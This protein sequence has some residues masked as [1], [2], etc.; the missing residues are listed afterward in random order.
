MKKL[1]FILAM[2]L[3]TG[4]VMAQKTTDLYQ[5]GS[6]NYANITQTASISNLDINTINAVQAGSSNSLYTAQKG[7]DNNIDLKQTGSSN[8]AAMTQETGDLFL[9]TG[10]NTANVVQGGGSSNYAK[11]TQSEEAG[12][13]SDGFLLPE[14]DRS[15][16]YAK[17]TQSGDANTYVLNQGSQVKIPNNESYLVQSGNGNYATI[18][19]KGIKNFSDIKQY[20]NN[21]NS[22][23]NQTGSDFLHT[24][25][26]DTSYSNQEGNNNGLTITQT[27]EVDNQLA[28]S[29][30][31]GTGNETRINQVA[32]T[33]QNV[34][35]W[36]YNHDSIIIKQVDTI[37][38][39]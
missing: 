7:W 39:L 14:Y 19:Q 29:I 33:V 25:T 11:L 36:Q 31:N 30:Q 38:Q 34:K 24:G 20:A 18:D 37:T 5:G 10:K 32:N 15:K 8:E 12:N 17:A 9:F 35:S 28:E 1:S 3:G 13:G 23:L 22:I 16:N 27:G 6:G 2:V 4:M 21:N 26:Y